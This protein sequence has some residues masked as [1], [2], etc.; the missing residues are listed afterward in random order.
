MKREFIL[1]IF[2]MLGILLTS[3]KKNEEKQI[4]KHYHDIS[5]EWDYDEK[6]H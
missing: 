6:M 5:L 4:D 2:I 3:C 1:I